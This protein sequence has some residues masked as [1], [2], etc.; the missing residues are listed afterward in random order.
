MSRTIKGTKGPGH[1]LTGAKRG[2]YPL[3]ADWKKTIER[4][5]RQIAKRELAAAVEGDGVGPQ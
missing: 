3:G 1:E 4:Q 5:K 2:W